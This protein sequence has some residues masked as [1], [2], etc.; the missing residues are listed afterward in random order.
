MADTVR[1]KVTSVIDGDTFDMSVTHIGK[2]NKTDY[3]DNE[4]IRIAGIDKP[5]LNTQAGQK[6]KG[7]L[8]QKLLGKEVRVTIQARDT[9]MRLVG[10]V[11][12]L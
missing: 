8:T 2:S 5:E 9:Y 11:D 1:G 3:N 10:T 12:V 4:R 6:A 7:T